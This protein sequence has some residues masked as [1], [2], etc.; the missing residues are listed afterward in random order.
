MPMH[1][2]IARG[3][4]VDSMRVSWNS[5]QSADAFSSSSDGHRV[6]F[7]TASGVLD[8]ELVAQTSTYSADDL[9]GSPATDVGF[10]DP[11]YFHSA[12]LTS[13][14]PG[15]TVYYRVG[16]DEFGWTEETSFVAFDGSRKETRM[17]LTAVSAG[18]RANTAAD[19]TDCIQTHVQNS[20]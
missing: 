1:R 19:R 10:V 7:G 16:S 11:G 2:H 13:L 4:D 12:L 15:E 9:C 20:D 17:L 8:S 3:E 14:V 6:Q 18:A 5:A